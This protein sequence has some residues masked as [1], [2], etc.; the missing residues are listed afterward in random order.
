MSAAACDFCD[1][2]FVFICVLVSLS[3]KLLQLS[4]IIVSQVLLPFWMYS[5]MLAYAL[6]RPTFH[7]KH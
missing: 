4:T 5:G 1:W 3:G 7:I 6:L 2:S